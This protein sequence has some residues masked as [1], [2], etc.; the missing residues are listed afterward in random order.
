MPI[1]V[2]CDQCGQAMQ[3]PDKFAGKAVKCPKCGARLVVPAAAVAP[4]ET[5]TTPQK[6]AAP[7]HPAAGR[8]ARAAQA[9]PRSRGLSIDDIAALDPGRPGHLIDLG[10]GLPEERRPRKD[11]KA[12][13]APGAVPSK[14]KQ[15]YAS[16]FGANFTPKGTAA[17]KK[18]GFPVG[19]VVKIAV[20]VVI[21]IG[22]WIGWKQLTSAAGFSDAFDLVEGGELAKA[23][24]KFKA[25]RATY[26]GEDLTRADAWVARIAMENK[27]NAGATLSMAE[28]VSSD[29]FQ[30]E[31]GRTSYANKALNLQ[32]KI[33]N[34]GTQPFT[35]RTE[36]FYLRGKLDVVCAFAQFKANNVEGVTVEPGKSFDANLVFHKI[37]VY[38]A[39]LHLATGLQKIYFLIFNNGQIYEKKKLNF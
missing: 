36:D 22:A 1:V 16:P 15:D 8:P 23:A 27:L 14:D 4:A 18:T 24:D 30:M 19:L 13:V 3:A 38:P 25:D 26:K 29:V 20:V 6:P 39:E 33:T 10:A 9:P 7:R 11:A 12:P 32:V 31:M 2:K 37:P 35:M 28:P 34:T 17:P 21:A 5:A